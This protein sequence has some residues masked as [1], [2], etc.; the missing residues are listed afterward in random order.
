MAIYPRTQIPKYQAPIRIT[1][2]YIKPNYL[3]D[4]ITSAIQG[5]G[6]IQNMNL[7]QQ[8]FNAK[9]AQQ[10]KQQDILNATQAG[11]AHMA[12]STAPTQQEEMFYEGPQMGK[13]SGSQ[14][15]SAHP[16]YRAL[17]PYTSV[18]ADAPGP[19]LD[20]AFEEMAPVY[21]TTTQP[22]MNP[23]ESVRAAM[24]AHPDARMQD[25][26][27]MASGI[28]ALE[29]PR[30]T[31][32]LTAAQIGTMLH[33]NRVF[34]RNEERHQ[35]GLKQDQQAL[36]TAAG[37]AASKMIRNVFGNELLPDFKYDPWGINPEPGTEAT[38][39]FLQNAEWF[40]LKGVDAYNAMM[41]DLQGAAKQMLL[42]GQEYNTVRAK[43][44]GIYMQGTKKKS[45]GWKQPE[46]P[47]L[48]QKQIEENRARRDALPPS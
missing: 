6:S 12:R 3:A 33:R 1:R 4:T 39:K 8:L 15:G 43:L 36:V 31:G 47:Q 41:Q 16:Y 35:A 2:P 29:N 37:E 34:D 24:Q 40:D 13:V 27:A 48:L 30:Q 28:H 32:G 14:M 45:S 23:M 18:Y 25:L 44:H 10:K 9:L 7:Q 46:I 38:M 5:Y 19:I 17:G 42:Q 22:G 21:G 20:N 11:Y 26:I